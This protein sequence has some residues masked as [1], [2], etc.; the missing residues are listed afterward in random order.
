M[1]CELGDNTGSVVVPGASNFTVKGYLNKVWGYDYKFLP[2]VG[3]AHI[4]WALLFTILFAFGI[5]FLN[6]QKR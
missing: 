1:T 2:A 3:I 5:K 4:G 6:F